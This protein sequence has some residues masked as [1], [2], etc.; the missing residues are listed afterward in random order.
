MAESLETAV[1]ILDKSRIGL[2]AEDYI[3]RKGN[4][5]RSL[6]HLGTVSELAYEKMVSR[7]KGA[8]HRR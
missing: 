2:F 1:I 5:Q 7:V 6:G 8:F 3:V 4:R